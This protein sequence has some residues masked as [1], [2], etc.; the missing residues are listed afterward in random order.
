MFCIECGTLLEQRQAFGQT[1][2]VCPNCGH[3]HFEDPKVAVGVVAELEG[4]IVLARRGHE[5]KLGGWS[6]PSG[7]VDAGELLEDAARREMA[8]ETGLQVQIEGLIGA[9]SS[10]GERTIF[11]AYAGRVTGGQLCVGEECLD[12][13]AFALEALP[14]LAFPHDAA[15]IAAWRLLRSTSPVQD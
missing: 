12:V 14:P 6:F 11:I 10:P 1:R 13:E 8:E 3:V 5:P 4:R 15:I 2:G 7:F 9:Y